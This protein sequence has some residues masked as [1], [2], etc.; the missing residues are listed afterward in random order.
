[1]E[2]VSNRAG[3]A[4]RAAQDAV[5]DSARE[6]SDWTMRLGRAGVAGQ[7]VLYLI[8]AWLAGRIALGGGGEE[9][10]SSGALSTLADQPFGVVLLVLLALSFLAYAAWQV[11]E[12]FGQGLGKPDAKERAKA[13]AKAIVGVVLLVSTIVVLTGGGQSSN[14]EEQA[15]ATALSW[16]GGRILVGLIGLGVIAFAGS[17]VYR[18]IKG[19][20]REKLEP[21]VD[22]RLIR[23]GQVG[24]VA[25]GLALATI[26]VLVITAAVQYDSEESGGLDSALQTLRDQPF[27]VFI[28][29]AIALGFAAWGIFCV[30]TA[31]RHKKA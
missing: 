20:I 23:L 1:M 11:L 18:G 17:L 8:L 29:L 15:T 10:S 12:A 3:R 4:G 30:L 16:P 27:G 2:S 5:P 7:G 26:G 25:R 21:G 13:A 31:R 6:A 28:V 9:A 24:D 19:K 22:Q 14:S